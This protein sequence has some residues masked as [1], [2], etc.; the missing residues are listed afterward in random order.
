[1]DYASI[2]RERRSFDRASSER[3]ERHSSSV[4][5]NVYLPSP[6]ERLELADT[7]WCEVFTRGCSYRVA[8]G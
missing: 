5:N 3:V 7:P 2:A 4:L 1:M 6:S 8:E